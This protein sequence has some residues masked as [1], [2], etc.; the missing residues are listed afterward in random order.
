MTV[1][2]RSGGSHSEESA[3]AMFLV[4]DFVFFQ[5]MRFDSLSGL[6][7]K[8]ASLFP[9]DLD[10]AEARMSR[11]ALNKLLESGEAH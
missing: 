5:F 1:L 3:P 10:V 4:C 6:Y 2:A 11:V 9:F 8:S 7:P